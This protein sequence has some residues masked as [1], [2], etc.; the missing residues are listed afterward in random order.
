MATEFKYTKE[1][2]AVMIEEILAIHHIIVK[3]KKVTLVLMSLDESPS[4]KLAHILKAK[5]PIYFNY[6]LQLPDGSREVFK[7]EEKK[8]FK[9]KFL[10]QIR[11]NMIVGVVQK[12]TLKT[13]FKAIMDIIK[14]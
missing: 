3:Y 5:K 10:S 7:E 9:I 8:V 6:R 12:P 2:T 1:E 4:V 11:N 13:K 14:S